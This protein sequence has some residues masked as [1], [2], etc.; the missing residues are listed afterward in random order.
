MLHVLIIGADVDLLDL[1]STHLR[2]LGYAVHTAASGT[3]GIATFERVSP[4]VTVVD[5]KMPGM[6]G[7]EVLKQLRE[8]RAV[9]VMLT[10]H[11]DIEDAVR[12]MRLGAESFLTKPVAMDHLAVAIERA[13]EKTVLRDRNHDLSVRLSRNF[14]RRMVRAGAVAA[15]VMASLGFGSAIG[16]MWSKGP[17]PAPIPVPFELADTMV[18]TNDV[19]MAW[20]PVP[21]ANIPSLRQSVPIT[22]NSLPPADAAAGF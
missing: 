19:P 22:P 2:Q 13:A 4:H 20:G 21:G 8:K 16:G 11:A 7:M 9:V 17:Q 15:L 3:E 18:V 1:L 5:L 12:A 10:G 6:S 14:K